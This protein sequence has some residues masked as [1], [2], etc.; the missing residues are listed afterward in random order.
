MRMCGRRCVVV[1]QSGAIR[2]IRCTMPA[3]YL[4]GLG[5]HAPTHIT[6]CCRHTHDERE[7]HIQR[8]DSHKRGCCNGPQGVV[9]QRARA[10]AMCRLHHDGGD[11]RLDA[12]KQT[13][14][15]RHIPPCDVH[16]RQRDEH[17]Q[18][19]QHKK[20]PRHHP[21]PALVH[22]PTDVSHQLLRFRP[23]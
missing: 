3:A 8:K 15:P 12:K 9:F 17:E 22:E 23:G 4:K 19:R 16:P 10:N 20:S 13:R 2:R 14:D 21:A 18:R 1:N 7:G 5:R 11:S 6:H